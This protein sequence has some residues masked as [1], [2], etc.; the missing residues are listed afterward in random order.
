MEKIFFYDSAQQTPTDSMSIAA[1][2]ED[3]VMVQSLCN[4]FGSAIFDRNAQQ[5]ACG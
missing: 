2:D 3:F 5:L 1:A 4:S